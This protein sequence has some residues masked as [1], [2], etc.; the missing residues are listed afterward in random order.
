MVQITVSDL[1][2]AVKYNVVMG[3]TV[4][5][6]ETYALETPAADVES[7]NFEINADAARFFKVVREPLVKEVK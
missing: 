3:E 7:A 6:L 1:V 4:D 2:P 5:K